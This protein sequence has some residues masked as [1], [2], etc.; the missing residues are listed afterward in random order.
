M[1]GQGDKKISVNVDDF[2]IDI[3][4]QFC[5]IAKQH[6]Q[7][8]EFMNLNNNKVK[9]VENHV[10]TKWWLSFGKCLE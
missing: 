2:V 3:Y 8:R 4:Y 7:L 6:K 10:S 9:K 5:R 1:P